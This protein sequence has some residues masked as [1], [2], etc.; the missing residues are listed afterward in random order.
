[1]KKTIVII[2][3]LLGFSLDYKLIVSYLNKNG[4]K[5]CSA[6]KYN[7]KEKFGETLFGLTAKDLD[8]FIK[9]IKKKGKIYLIGVSMGGIIAAYWLE[10]L[11]GKKI[12]NDCITICAPF[13]GSYL[14]Y[15][16]KFKGIRELRPN[17]KTLK[18]LRQK[19]SKSNVNYYGI[20]NPLDLIV[21]PGS[22]AKLD[23]FKKTKI[24]FS[25][26]HFFT[27]L[28]KPTKEFIFEIIKQKP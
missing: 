7:H 27:T 28:L 19:I 11:N 15:P 2:P 4:I 18:L 9:N 17:N 24:V 14:A 10:F 3:G 6:F 13:H 21:M 20:W 25:L 16:S 5:D 26:F 22:S 1:M 23:S 8:K 12:C